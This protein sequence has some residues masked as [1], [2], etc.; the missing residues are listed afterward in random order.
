MDVIDEHDQ[1]R[2]L[3]SSR[4]DAELTG[5]LDCVYRIG[6]AVRQTDDLRL[7]VL[8]LKKERGI[9]GGIERV[10]N[11]AEDGAAIGLDDLGSLALHRSPESVV[12]SQEIP[13]FAA[14]PDDGLRC[15]VGIRPGIPGP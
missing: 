10:A 14:T 7:G 6:A 9:V 5:R 3:L 8:S 1:A 4:D 2:E 12:C 11:R 15:P 13:A